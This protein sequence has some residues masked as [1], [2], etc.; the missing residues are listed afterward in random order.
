[1]KIDVRDFNLKHIFECGQCFRWNTNLN[2]SVRP[3]ERLA[4]PVGPQAGEDVEER[5]DG[6]GHEDGVVVPV[7]PVP[8]ELLGGQ[9]APGQGGQHQRHP[10][11]GQADEVGGARQH[12]QRDELDL[13]GE[14]AG[15]QAGGLGGG[16]AVRGFAAD[17]VFPGARRG[18]R[19]QDE[20]DRDEEGEQ[21][22]QR[23]AQAQE[24]CWG[25]LVLAPSFV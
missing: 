7:R 20:Q 3:C 21:A 1:M 14:Q 23:Q 18:E 16:G 6:D 2:G 4:L 22:V 10:R 8:V 13:R 19:R 17:A 9:E 11:G 15:E 25:G 12:P 5:A 24:R